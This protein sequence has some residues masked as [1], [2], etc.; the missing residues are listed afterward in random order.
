MTKADHTYIYR[1]IR[2]NPRA[3]RLDFYCLSF[4]I[5]QPKTIDELWRITAE[6]DR[7]RLLEF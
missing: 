3:R 4:P 1:H 2:D 5:I 6:L 7:I